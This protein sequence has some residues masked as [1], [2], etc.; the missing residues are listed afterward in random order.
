ML[1][2][3]ITAMHFERFE[4]RYQVRFESGESVVE[5]LLRW[6]TA[7]RITFATLSGIGAVRQARVSYWNAQTREYEP[8]VLD[9]QL[10][11]VSL[12][13]NATIKDGAPFVHIHVSL[14]RR[15]LSIVGG[16]L[17]DLIVHPN[18]EIT[19]EPEPTEVRRVIDE[20]S[21]LWVMH[22]PERA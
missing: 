15:D 7:E 1:T 17:N 10:E 14:G 5:P 11:I 12:I 3:T 8:H 22:L 21:G 19:V 18:L 20:G 16:H 13:G 6:M 2:A 4:S 9:E